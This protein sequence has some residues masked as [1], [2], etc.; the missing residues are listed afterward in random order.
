MSHSDRDNESM[1][2]TRQFLGLERPALVAVVDYLVGRFGTPTTLDLGGLVV[3]L[4]GARA[5]RRLLEVLVDRAEA[6]SLTLKPPEITTVGKLPEK[7]YTAKLPFADEL[8]QQFA[9]AEALRQFDRSKLSRL[10][11]DRPDDEETERW[12]DLGRLLQGLH[13]ELASDV[14]D[15][16]DVARLGKTLPSFTETERWR[17][18]TEIQ[19]AYLDELDRLELWDRQTA[20][21]FAIEHQE[22]R[23]S[24]P[25]VVVGAVDLNRSMRQ[26]L[27]QVADQVT[28]LVYAPADWAD[29]FDEHGCLIPDAWQNVALNIPDESLRLAENPNDQSE[30][31]V[32]RIAEY[33]G[34][35]RTDEITIGLADDRIVPQLTRQLDE[36]KL[37]NRFGPGKPLAGMNVFRM[38]EDLAAFAKSGRYA[39]F[40]G[41][42]RHPDIEVWLM[43]I[44]ILPGWL[45]E[46]DDYYNEHLPRRIDGVWIGD[47]DSFPRCATHLTASAV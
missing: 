28:S 36:C 34:R 11:A 20:R 21:L 15:F 31:V 13:R 37:A 29:R 4:P 6:D 9:W 25:I 16:A 8:V 24:R 17:T 33:N 1:P 7:L 14:L 32:R 43:Q 38:L 5:G 39:E 44:G 30:A 22:C 45:E 19:R 23:S 18:L 2:I 3:V 10:V 12:L 35:F 26:M 40:A 46:L 41:L 42:V 47:N 27:D